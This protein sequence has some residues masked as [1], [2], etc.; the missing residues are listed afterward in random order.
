LLYFNLYKN[1]HI[2]A[3]SH[4]LEVWKKLGNAVCLMHQS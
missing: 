1:I 3:I 2:V 4:L